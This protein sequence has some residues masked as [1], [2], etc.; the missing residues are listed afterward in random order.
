METHCHHTHSSCKTRGTRFIWWNANFPWSY[1]Y[2][3]VCCGPTHPQIWAAKQQTTN[4]HALHEHE[5]TPQCSHVCSVAVGPSAFVW[6]VALRTSLPVR[7]CFAATDPS[8]CLLDPRP[9]Y[10]GDSPSCSYWSEI[11]WDFVSPCRTSGRHVS[12]A[13]RPTPSCHEPWMAASVYTASTAR[14]CCSETSGPHPYQN[15]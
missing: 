9:C 3:A 12:K 5:Y 2:F 8:H 14:P 7:P 6:M 15:W 1:N 4:T 10:H 11:D 13:H